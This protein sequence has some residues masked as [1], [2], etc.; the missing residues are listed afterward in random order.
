MLDLVPSWREG[1][2]DSM[3]D[4]K[5]AELMNE[6]CDLDLEMLD[7][8]APPRVRPGLDRRAPAARPSAGARRRLLP[9]RRLWRLWRLWWRLRSTGPE[10]Q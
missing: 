7:V 5:T 3:S 1:M 2:P 8:Q 4:S 10:A 6:I 9:L